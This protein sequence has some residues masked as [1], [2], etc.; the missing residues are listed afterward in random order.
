VEE[1][2]ENARI[3]NTLLNDGFVN[4]NYKILS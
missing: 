1:S 2:G 3:Q 4:W